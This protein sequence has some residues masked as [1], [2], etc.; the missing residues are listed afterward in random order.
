MSPTDPCLG[1][2][3]HDG[4]QCVDIDPS[5]GS[6]VCAV[7]IV[8]ETCA[9]AC[10][11]MQ[12]VQMDGG[13]AEITDAP[14]VVYKGDF[15]HAYLQV[16][17][18]YQS[19]AGHTGP[20]DLIPVVRSSNGSVSDGVVDGRRTLAE[21][22]IGLRNLQSA[23]SVN[24]S[25]RF[26]SGAAAGTYSVAFS[27]KPAGAAYNER[28]RSVVAN[29][30]RFDIV[31]EYV[32]LDG[33]ETGLS[34]TARPDAGSSRPTVNVS[35]SYL[36]ATPVK[37]A[38]Q[39]RCF[40]PPSRRFGD[41]TNCDNL[42]R[43]FN[44]YAIPERQYGSANI[45]AGP[46]SVALSAKMFSGVS[47]DPRVPFKIDVS[48]GRYSPGPARGGWLE[49][50]DRTDRF[51]LAV[52]AAAARSGSFDG[53]ATAGDADEVAALVDGADGHSAEG[54]PSATGTEFPYIIGFLVGGLLFAV[55][56]TVTIMAV[57]RRTRSSTAPGPIP[58]VG[59]AE[60]SRAAL[61]WG[62]P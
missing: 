9:L 10:C 24:V 36:A 47:R 30:H 53:G 28:Y 59:T 62:W 17:L 3:N 34:F 50:R 57:F 4:F 46:T 39:I 8:A 42:P 7:P 19:P 58:R 29:L 23:G 13:R 52:T 27:I 49:T 48:M 41:L 51:D 5:T 35:F 2:V 32:R 18:N 40:V 31:A 15:K 33:E 14:A 20:I 61:T 1:K 6:D 54:S 60:T 55:L 11:E 25:I 38:I 44:S 37:F 22:A 16:Q 26:L 45:D 56:G 21:N 12:Q 43:F